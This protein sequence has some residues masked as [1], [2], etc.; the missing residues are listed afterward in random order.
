MGQRARDVILT[1]LEDWVMTPGG[2]SR[3]PLILSAHRLHSSATMPGSAKQPAG[4]DV[5]YAFVAVVAAPLKRSRYPV[6]PGKKRDV[7]TW[8]TLKCNEV[9]PLARQRMICLVMRKMML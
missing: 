7:V 8:N 2:F 5:S 6:Y 9:L 3:S 4:G 1:R